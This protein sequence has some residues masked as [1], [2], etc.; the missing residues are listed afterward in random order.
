VAQQLPDGHF[1]LARLSELR[2]VVDY[3]VVV[4]EQSARHRHSN[5]KGCNTFG[6]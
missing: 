1:G 2:P 3:F 6:R 5:G 4:A